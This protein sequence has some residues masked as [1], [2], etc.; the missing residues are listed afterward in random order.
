MSDWSD[1]DEQLWNAM[2]S[3][4]LNSSLE[5][6]EQFVKAFH[7]H[8]ELES[9]SKLLRQPAEG[10]FNT[11]D[12][13]GQP[14]NIG[15]YQVRRLLGRGAF[16]VVYLADDPE[17]N[18]HVVIKVPRPQ[19]FSSE[20]AAERFLEEAKL[21]AQLKHPGIVTV[22]EDRAGQARRRVL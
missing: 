20:G 8:Q 10:Q 3:G 7:A 5:G 16:G 1:K 19:R 12:S 21:A 22:Y 17:L 6:D 2:E 18:R 4:R 9:L 11:E 15:R 14:E 13:G